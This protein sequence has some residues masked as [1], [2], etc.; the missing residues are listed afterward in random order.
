[1]KEVPLKPHQIEALDYET[2]CAQM[3]KI[4]VPDHCKLSTDDIE[5]PLLLKG[6]KQTDAVFHS[7]NHKPA[8]IDLDPLNARSGH[9]AGR[10]KPAGSAAH[11][12]EAAAAALL[13][14]DAE[15][16]FQNV[17]VAWTTCLLVRGYIYL[18]LEDGLYFLCLGAAKHSALMWPMVVTRYSGRTFLS[19]SFASTAR[20][21]FVFNDR[22]ANPH[23]DDPVQEKFAGVKTV[24][25]GRGNLPQAVWHLGTCLELSGCPVLLIPF[26]LQIGAG[27]TSEELKKFCLSFKVPVV[28]INKN[29]D[30][31]A[32]AVALTK[33]V[34]PDQSTEEQLRMAGNVIKGFATRPLGPDGGPDDAT[35]L[36]AI[37]NLDADNQEQL[38][39]FRHRLEAKQAADEIQKRIQHAKIQSNRETHPAIKA[40]A[41]SGVRDC[42]LVRQLREVFG[43]YM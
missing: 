23:H 6:A 21:E 36:E 30:H 17:I 26:A 12:R 5:S 4:G 14:L 27:L 42:R 37:S 40:L 13:R 29:V 20:A 43:S 24:V 28:K 22:V 3:R 11:A 10:W 1:M 2:V 7:E 8:N 15:N 39:S 38:D 9:P 31:L 18:R 35:T 34:F 41:P 32:F 19:V 33:W 16:D 25:R